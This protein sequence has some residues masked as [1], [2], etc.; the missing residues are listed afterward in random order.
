MD[1][2][3]VAAAKGPW[4]RFLQQVL[5]ELEAD[6]LTIVDDYVPD[7]CL[8][9]RTATVGSVV[10]GLARTHECSLPLGQACDACLTKCDKCSMVMCAECLAESDSSTICDD[11]EACHRRPL[12]QCCFCDVL[13]CE[14]CQLSCDTCVRVMCAGCCSGRHHDMTCASIIL[15]RVRDHDD[16]EDTLN[17]L[18]QYGVVID[19]K[20]DNSS[21][22]PPAPRGI[23]TRDRRT[24][25]L[26]TSEGL[27]VTSAT[28]QVPLTVSDSQ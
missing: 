11:C 12:R 26:G 23:Y 4:F 9:C 15:R 17:L 22:A 20:A 6:V 13:L 27:L 5:P 24:P 18:L 25:F 19:A 21:A 10:C 7:L 16:D 2:S 28:G 14:D 3:N 1:A 8:G